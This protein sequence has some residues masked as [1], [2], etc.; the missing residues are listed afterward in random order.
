[1]SDDQFD[2]LFKY[3]E[4][5]FADIDRRFERIDRRFDSLMNT[6]DSFAKQM[7]IYDHERLALGY[8][9]DRHERWH[10]QTAKAVG[11]NLQT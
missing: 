6:M 11:I 5:R 3:M 7:E 8:K 4:R 2:R 10:H 9:V 1:M